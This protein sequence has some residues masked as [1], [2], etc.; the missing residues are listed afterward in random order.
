MSTFNLDRNEDGTYFVMCSVEG[1]E[2][3]QNLH[4]ST[5]PHSEHELHDEAINRQLNRV[6][7]GTYTHQSIAD[8]NDYYLY[9]DGWHCDEHTH[10]CFDC[11]EHILGTDQDA[12][13]AGFERN[14][15]GGERWACPEHYP[16]VASQE[17]WCDS[18][19]HSVASQPTQSLNNNDSTPP[20]SE[21]EDES[22]G[23]HLHFKC[24]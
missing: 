15:S 12:L 10:I 1:C 17:Q 14:W 13:D 22:E 7:Q 21:S 6:L 2:N 8:N 5:L 24:P 11:N 18:S 20:V 16:R 3:F 19:Q 23:G 9:E 4:T